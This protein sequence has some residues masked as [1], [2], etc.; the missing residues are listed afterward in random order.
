MILPPVFYLP[1]SISF[2]GE[3][4]TRV[5]GHS[6][7]SQVQ[8][9]TAKRT[10]N[11]GEITTMADKSVSNSLDSVL[12]YIRNEILIYELKNTFIRGG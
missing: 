10:F 7:H 9:F 8:G 12:Y 11:E 5:S 2:F 4:E 1:V 6:I 3:T